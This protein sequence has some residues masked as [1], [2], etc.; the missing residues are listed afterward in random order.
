MEQVFLD[1]FHE[2]SQWPHSAFSLC[3]SGWQ[4]PSQ[5][6]DAGYS[7]ARDVEPGAFVVDQQVGPWPYLSL[8]ED[9]L[10]IHRLPESDH[11]CASGLGYLLMWQ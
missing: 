4:G 11:F 2:S 7:F 3:Y 1:R 10:I 5:L 6:Q 9:A 8:Q